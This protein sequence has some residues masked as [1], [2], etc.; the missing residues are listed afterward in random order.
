MS[1]CRNHHGK[2]RKLLPI[3]GPTE[4][5]PAFLETPFGS[6]L[7]YK[8]IRSSEM[9]GKLSL[10][11]MS[12]LI[13]VVAPW[14]HGKD[15]PCAEL[16]KDA[17]TFSN[18]GRYQESI[19]SAKQ[20][21]KE[22]KTYSSM[23]DA[24]AIKALA[25]LGDI[26]KG[27]GNFSEAEMLY[28]RALRSAG[29]Q[30]GQGHPLTQARMRDLV[31]LYML[32]GKYSEAE[33]LLATSM[34]AIR[35]EGRDHDA[36]FASLLDARATILLSQGKM[37]EAR[38]L[39]EKALE[40][41]EMAAKYTPATHKSAV[42]VLN[43]LASIAAAQGK[44][45]D[46]D[47]LYN[48]AL[49]KLGGTA[50][51]S[52]GQAARIICSQGDLYRKQDRFSLAASNYRKV[53][54]MSCGQTGLSEPWVMTEALMGLGDI[55]KARKSYSQAEELYTRALLTVE[56]QGGPYNAM[57]LTRI[58][59]NIGECCEYSGRYSEAAPLYKRA[60]MLHSRAQLP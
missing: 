58:L 20:A 23:R 24:K 48:R 54:G 11:L 28:R 27:K 55:Y 53:I 3:N 51:F 16:L 46:A 47:K 31:G 59:R 9:R 36:D 7:I 19:A 56:K 41:Y 18:Q 42:E 50:D 2:T 21:F 14:A 22:A 29:E 17:I 57:V 37:Q 15:K 43:S 8:W 52:K 25:V 40:L 34:N 30:F 6:Q 13:L 33:A 60:T 5:N 45:G 32:Q 4:P 39:Y 38:G 12:V 49:L 1:L 26:R 35:R 10:G 44:P